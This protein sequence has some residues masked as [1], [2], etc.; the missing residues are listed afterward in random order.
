MSIN[1]LSE[2]Q[3]KDFWENFAAICKIP[4]PSGKEA[5][6]CWFIKNFS[7]NLGL[8]TL[9][10]EAGNLI[11][12]KPATVGMENCKGVIL[13]AH[14]DMVPQKNAE[15]EHDFAIDPIQP[16]VDGEWVK[17]KGTTL[18]ADDGFGVAS[19]M[20]VLQSETLKHGPLEALFT[21]DEEVGLSGAYALKPGILSGEILLNLD[22]E[23]E[24]ELTIGSAGG[25]FI[26]G[27]FVYNKSAVPQNVQTLTIKVNGLKG[28]HSAVAIDK[29]IANAIKILGR[30]LWLSKRKFALNLI[31]IDGGTAYNAIPREA[32]AVVTLDSEQY[33]AF[34]DFAAKHC[35]FLA[36]NFVELQ[37]LQIE[38]STAGST[39]NF[40]IE[41]QDQEMLLNVLYACP[42][43]IIG[44]SKSIPGLIETSTNLAMIKTDENSFKVSVMS[45]SAVEF[46]VDDMINT[47]TALFNLRGGRVKVSDKFP[48]WQP[49]P[50]LPIVEL[51]T[52]IYTK[53]FGQK[54]KITATHAGLECGVFL[55][56]Y[57]NLQMVSFGPIVEDPHSPNERLN[58]KS[59]GKYWEFLTA[60]LEN[61]PE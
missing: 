20:A 17:A 19:I 33:E 32:S 14:L 23:A 43:G 15:V 26:D 42:H 35:G 13:Q 59:V 45:R 50:S 7:E 8:K 49:I 57:P 34:K 46:L 54:P 44:M 47:N 41:P 1:A 55:L 48:A 31:A 40:I 38:V 25:I 21:V 61:I 60:V 30:L 16:Y 11:V 12:K 37:G 22:G 18:G 24:D 5:K 52:Q 4:H 6:L 29:P 36:T 51:M 9:V 27:E 2:L 10:D 53:K 58:I 56:S 3:P 28:G 39:A